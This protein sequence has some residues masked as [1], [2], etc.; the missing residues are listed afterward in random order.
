MQT[1]SND[2]SV[3]EGCLASGS[4]GGEDL[5]RIK[6]DGIDA[7]Q[8]LHDGN[9]DR[10]DELWPVA[11][12]QQGTQGVLDGIGFTRLQH[13]VLELQLH[14]LLTTNPLQDLHEESNMSVQ[15][16]SGDAAT[17]PAVLHSSS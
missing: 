11:G 2:D 3:E 7:G 4:K 6:H 10:D 12:L 5:G 1:C 16:R 13:D 15:A 9:E 14:V 8:L 17:T